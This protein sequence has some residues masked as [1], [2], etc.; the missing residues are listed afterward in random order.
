MS[1]YTRCKSTFNGSSCSNE[2]IYRVSGSM[3]DEHVCCASC[4]AEWEQAQHGIWGQTVL[5][6]LDGSSSIIIK[7]DGRTKKKAG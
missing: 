7:K 6:P 3:I 4:A 1:K 2:A 5:T